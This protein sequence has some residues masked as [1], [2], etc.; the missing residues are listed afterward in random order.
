MIGDLTD[1][2]QS[3]VGNGRQADPNKNLD[4]WQGQAYELQTAP[5]RREIIRKIGVLSVQFQKIT[6]TWCRNKEARSAGWFDNAYEVTQRFLRKINCM[7]A[8]HQHMKEVLKNGA[9]PTTII[10]TE[11]GATTVYLEFVVFTFCINM[12]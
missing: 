9:S 8:W 7:M 11:R 2:I 1:E 12:E 6:T 3:L 4:T 5:R 10:D